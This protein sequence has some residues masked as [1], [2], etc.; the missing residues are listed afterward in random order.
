MALNLN[1]YSLDDRFRMIMREIK[2]VPD[3]EELQEVPY[4][5]EVLETITKTY[6][7]LEK[8]LRTTNIANTL[9][10]EQSP[11]PSVQQL[12]TMVSITE[13]ERI[14][15]GD[16]PGTRKTAAAGLAKYSIERKLGKKIKTLVL[17]PS[18]LISNW[19]MRLD[20]YHQEEP[21]Y[22]V[23]TPEDKW[24]D[25]KRAASNDVDY[26]FVSYD[27]LYKDVET[28][29]G[30][31]KEEYELHATILAQQYTN[32][33]TAAWKHHQ[34]LNCNYGATEES[35]IEEICLGIAFEEAVQTENENKKVC[36]TLERIL[37]RN[38]PDET[39]KH[40]F[41]LIADEFHN[42]RDASLKKKTNAFYR[43]AQRARFA[44][45]LSGTKT[46]DNIG[47]IAVI[48]SILDNPRFP[49]PKDFIDAVG[50]NPA[51]VRRFYA[52]WEKKPVLKTTDIGEDNIPK[53][54]DITFTLN[55]KEFSLYF[56]I[57]NH[58]EIAEAEK[59]LLLRY[60]TLDAALIDPRRYLG[61]PSMRNKLL[62]IQK[63]EPEAFE[64]ITTNNSTRYQTLEGIIENIPYPEK[65]VIFSKF[66]LGVIPVIEARL[67]AKGENIVK[68]DQ[69][70]GTENKKIKLTTKEIAELKEKGIYREQKYR[71]DLKRSEK[72]AIHLAGRRT[73]RYSERDIAV[74]T[75]QCNPDIDGV[76]ATYGTLRE[77]R[78]LTAVNHIIKLDRE[79]QPGV[80]RQAIGR[81]AGRSGQQRKCHIYA[82]RAN[83]TQDDGIEDHVNRKERTI[84]LAESCEERISSEDAQSLA[85]KIRPHN[86]REIRPYM[87][88]SH[89]LVR[90]ILGNLSGAGV[91]AMEALVEQGLGELFAQNYNYKWE[92]SSSANIG[93]LIAMTLAFKGKEF[94]QVI[95]LG[96][97][98]AQM[99]RVLGRTTTCMDYLKEQL[100]IGKKEC[101][102][103]GFQIKTQQGSIHRIPLPSE[104]YD[105]SVASN[106]FNLLTLQE[107]AEAMRE[108]QRILKKGAR[109]IW[110]FP[111]SATELEAGDLSIIQK[112]KRDFKKAGFSIDEEV[113]GRYVA[114]NAIDL[115]TGNEITSETKTFLLAAENT[116]KGIIEEGMFEL[117]VD[118]SYS[119]GKG[120]QRNVLEPMQGIP[121]AQ[122]EVCLAFE[123][124]DSGLELKTKEKPISREELRRRINQG[125]KT[126]E[127]AEEDIAK[128]IRAL[129]E[130]ERN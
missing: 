89:Q 97:G 25:L 65:Y 6:G 27:L 128:I 93:R 55:E 83:A 43:L 9:Q 71:V 110:V 75:A 66:S 67:R 111:P 105:L 41:Y 101:E 32:D 54:K 29:N 20:E 116:E 124:I 123:N 7:T 3:E 76:L 14:I 61:S 85:G 51:A 130:G 49:N 52:Q 80:E 62:K 47:D 119:K 28:T 13:R 91:S 39:T 33:K 17:C 19:M 100:E 38:D 73:L 26:I 58:S 23:I 122:A 87:F 12:H 72:E 79:Y 125:L 4:F 92:L 102:K 42:V 94:S 57:Q 60:V 2:R 90:M 104:T 37:T 78:D 113:T 121:Q 34:G 46:P 108:N 81:A 10:V 64:D 56:A 86:E 109:G 16:E 59:L 48:A 36:D 117:K 24:E 40:D 118:Y 18:Y 82:L 120:K 15:I 53:A 8:Y 126:G 22:C 69:T 1:K 70:I 31:S 63:E 5:S 106:V 44:A 68:V 74:L 35:T 107:R 115:N 77:G 103:L 127:L 95:E 129:I 99:A 11:F 50:N 112:L 114:R 21:S 98:P 88:S 96:S 45:F 30:G 84:I